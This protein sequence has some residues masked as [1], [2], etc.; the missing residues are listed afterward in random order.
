MGK[1]R[2]TKLTATQCRKLRELKRES[3]EQSASQLIAKLGWDAALLPTAQECLASRRKRLNPVL[4]EKHIL[5]IWTLHASGLGYRRICRELGLDLKHRGAVEHVIRGRSHVD[6]MPAPFK[7]SGF[8]VNVRKDGCYFYEANN[9][10]FTVF[11]AK[12]G[13]ATS[14]A[15]PGVT[16]KLGNY[17]RCSLLALRSCFEW[18]KKAARKKESASV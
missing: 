9:D 5:R 16:R 18:F 17:E 12:N 13:I 15:V 6:L 1:S 14:E 7:P 4:T 3:P 2:A 11:V 10:A 8:V